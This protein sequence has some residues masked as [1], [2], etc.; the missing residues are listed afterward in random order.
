MKLENK[1]SCTPK[2]SCRGKGCAVSPDLLLIL[3]LF[4]LLLLLLLSTKGNNA[5]VDS[6][7]VGYRELNSL[8]GFN[9]LGIR[10][11][12]LPGLCRPRPWLSLRDAGLSVI[13]AAAKSLTWV[14]ALY[15]WAFCL[16]EA[17]LFQPAARI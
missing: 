17:S 6:R 15:S 4:A 7:E 13:L 10:G 8:D 2:P 16:I 9:N 3:K 1:Q 11:P 12:P 14:F 5:R